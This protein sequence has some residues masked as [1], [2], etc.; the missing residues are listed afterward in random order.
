MKLKRFYDFLFHLRLVMYFRCLN[1]CMHVSMKFVL[2]QFFIVSILF[3]T[4]CSFTNIATNSLLYKDN[5]ELLFSF[6]LV[7]S[8]KT[9]CLCKDKEGKYLVYRFGTSKKIELEYP[10]RLDASSWKAFTLNG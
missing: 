9:V 8:K 7:N 5:E 10:K 3:F 2:L 1:R 6:R 4:L